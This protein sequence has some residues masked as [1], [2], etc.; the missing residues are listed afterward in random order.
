MPIENCARGG[1]GRRSAVADSRVNPL[2]GQKNRVMQGANPCRA[3]TI[4]PVAKVKNMDC[5]KCSYNMGDPVDRTESNTTTK[6][7]QP[8]QHTGDIYYCPQCQCFYLDDF[9]NNI[10]R[11]WIY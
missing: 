7:A 4:A 10:I 6:R 1:I 9:L 5:E 3:Q 2:H 8:G 11:I